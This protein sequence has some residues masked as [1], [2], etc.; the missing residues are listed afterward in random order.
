[1]K[2]GHQKVCMWP[3]LG[4]LLFISMYTK[5]AHKIPDDSLAS[6]SISWLEHNGCRVYY[7]AWLYVGFGGLNSSPHVCFFLE[8]LYPLDHLSFPLPIFPMGYTINLSITILD[9]WTYSH[10][11]ESLTIYFRILL[12]TKVSLLPKGTYF[13]NSVNI[14]KIMFFLKIFL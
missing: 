4:L 7:N 14:T 1:M 6:F 3:L 2:N 8:V 12:Q 11:W 9:H 13:M 10:E 5:L